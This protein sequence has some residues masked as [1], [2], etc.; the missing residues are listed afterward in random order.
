MEQEIAI[1]IADLSGYTS[2]T[3]THGAV[4]AADLIDKYMKIVENS[5]VGSSELHQRAGDEALIVSRSADDLLSTAVKLFET[6]SVEHEFLQIHGGLHYGSLLKRNDHYFGNAINL[7]ARIASKASSG[8]LWCSEDFIGALTGLPTVTFASRG[9]HDL[10]NL[11]NS[12]TLFELVINGPEVF[13]IDPV[14]KMQIHDKIRAVQHP[15]IPNIYFC[16]QH[17][18]DI[19]HDNFISKK[20]DGR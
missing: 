14:C 10:K 12:N 17:C 2:L 3:D 18:L 4:A 13:Y 20:N 1:L 6:T 19:Y 7:A 16:S 11:R 8:S 15:A 9:A 5:L